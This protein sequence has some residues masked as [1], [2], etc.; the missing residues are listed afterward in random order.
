L[1][2]IPDE[3]GYYGAWSEV[4]DEFLAQWPELFEIAQLMDGISWA[5][6]AMAIDGAAEPT[7]SAVH[8]INVIYIAL[9]DWERQQELLS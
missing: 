3:T 2:L 4:P 5:Q 9:C 8:N 7:G 1:R 6:L